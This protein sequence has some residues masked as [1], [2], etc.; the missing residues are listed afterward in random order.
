MHVSPS[1]PMPPADDGA[2]HSELAALR[3][4]RW[5]QEQELDSLR[6][7]IVVYRQ[8]ATALA[9][10]ITELQHELASTRTP[11]TRKRVCAAQQ[12]L[13]LT[14]AGDVDAPAVTA[15]LIGESLSDDHTENMVEAC[16]AIAVELLSHR[17]LR[18]DT[19]QMLSLRIRHSEN[20]IGIELV[21]PE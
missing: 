16:Q 8:G 1:P 3:L 17:L 20:A 6:E 19:E 11:T 2:A 10:Q 21:P 14:L 15:L 13:E 12:E 18:A 7:T 5:Q 9:S 4:A